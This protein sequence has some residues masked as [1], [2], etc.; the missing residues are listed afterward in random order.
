M[1]G[2]SLGGYLAP[3]G[4]SGE[5]RLRA[6]VCDPGQFDFT[7]RFISM[8]SADDWQRVL[9]ADPVMDAQLEG[10]LADDRSASSTGPG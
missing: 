7:S 1:V 2:R 6:L 8:F 5:P 9:D 3:R 4:A 10:F